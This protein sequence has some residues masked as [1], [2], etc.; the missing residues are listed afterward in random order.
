MTSILLKGLTYILS[1]KLL[2]AIVVS[3][4]EVLVKRTDNTVDDEI[5]AKVKEYMK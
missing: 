4:C 1:T 5:L 3:T 2:K